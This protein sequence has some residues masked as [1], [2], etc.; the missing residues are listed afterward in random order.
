MKVPIAEDW[1]RLSKTPRII[2]VVTIG[3]SHHSFFLIKNERSS[4]IVDNLE[5]ESVLPDITT[6]FKID[7]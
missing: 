6:P 7:F 3:I 2:R 4:E 1:A 5:F